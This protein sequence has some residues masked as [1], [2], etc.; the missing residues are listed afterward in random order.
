MTAPGDGEQQAKKTRWVFANKPVPADRLKAYQDAG[1]DVIM[2]PITRHADYDAFVKPTGAAGA[3]SGDPEYT[4]GH[5]PSHPK[6]P[7]YSYRKNVDDFELP[8]VEHGL[9]GPQE[10]WWDF[11]HPFQRGANHQKPEPQPDP[12]GKYIIGR[13]S[14][15]QSK[16]GFWVLQGELGPIAKQNPQDD[17]GWQFDMDLWL[18]VYRNYGAAQR[19][20]G[21]EVLFCR[22]T[23]EA[24]PGDG[25]AATKDKTGY[26][27]SYRTAPGGKQ[28]FIVSCWDHAANGYAI[29]ADWDVSKFDDT[30][31]RTRIHV[32]DD[33]LTVALVN[34]DTAAQLPDFPP[35]VSKDD[36]DQNKKRLG[37]K[38]GGNRGGYV[39]FG[40]YIDNGPPA[41]PEDPESAAFAR[42]VATP[43]D[44]PPGLPPGQQPPPP[45]PQPPPPGPPPP[46]P[47]PPPP[48]PPP[49]P[50]PQERTHTV[51][52]GE[53]LSGIAQQYGV[54]QQSIQDANNIK[55]PDSIKEGQVLKIP[56]PPAGAT[57][58]PPP[59]PAP[60]PQE[61]PAPKP[62]PEEPKPPPPAEGPPPVPIPPSPGQGG[63]PALPP[64]L[65]GQKPIEEP[66]P[67][68]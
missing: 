23:D 4:A 10:N 26:C 40:R 5:V 67:R 28:Q 55:N 3:L 25:L 56:A 22:A 6:W 32:R 47:Q 58:P 49:P 62:Q 45:G 2:A 39:L 13:E 50:P 43:T 64:G 30:W 37:S 1:Y 20:V 61:E 52:R 57:P 53:T 19:I 12:G 54:S 21:A 38:D 7:N 27:L 46:A 44:A 36:R 42:W 29:L 48:E 11:V 9:I 66:D 18:N 34:R 33:G 59:Q 14:E 8:N 68:T 41:P 17:L 16:P 63:D 24:V 15:A 51:K 65:P 31:I 35:Y 60:P